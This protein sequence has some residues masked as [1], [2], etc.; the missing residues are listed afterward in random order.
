MVPHKTMILEFP[1]WIDKDLYSHFC[2]GYFDGDGCISL[3]K[4]NYNKSATINMVGTRMFLE[5]VA[6]IIK[7]DTGVEVYVNR[8][9]RAKDPICVLRCGIKNDVIKVLDWLYRDATIYMQRKYDKYKE[10]FKNINNSC[11]V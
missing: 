2:R 5:K 7:C 4:N 10:F 3:A 8:D 9:N 1:D 11:C 6:E